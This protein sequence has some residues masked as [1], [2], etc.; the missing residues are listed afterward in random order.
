MFIY[1][2]LNVSTLDITNCATID[3]LVKLL[4]VFS[5]VVQWFISFKDFK[6]LLHHAFTSSAIVP[7][8]HLLQQNGKKHK[9]TT[10]VDNRT[11]PCT[12][13]CIQQTQV[14]S[15]FRRMQ[16][17]YHTSWPLDSTEATDTET[18][19]LPTVLMPSTLKNTHFCTSVWTQC[20][21]RRMIAI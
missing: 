10:V 5:D 21:N 19:A 8:E 17:L 15:V 20:H 3:L 18:N 1:R 2:S 13:P 9:A 4:G 6:F 11:A 16:C 7:L 14:L 12:K